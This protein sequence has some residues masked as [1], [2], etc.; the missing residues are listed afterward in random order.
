[1]F[2][3]NDKN[4]KEIVLLLRKLEKKTRFV[5]RHKKEKIGNARL[6]RYTQEEI[7]RL[8]FENGSLSASVLCVK[9]GL[10]SDTLWHGLDALENFKKDEKTVPLVKCEISV[11]ARVNEQ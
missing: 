10:K 11:N 1:V 9:L 5:T 6:L 4:F 7:L 2:N 8:L 3:K